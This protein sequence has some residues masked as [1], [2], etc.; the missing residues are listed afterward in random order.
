MAQ[1][2]DRLYKLLPAIYRHRD[3]EQGMP[4]RALLQVIAEQVNLVEADIAQLYENWFIETCQD[5]VVPYIGDLVGYQV[6]HEAGEPGDVTT[7][8]GR[9]HN[10]IL[11]SRRDVANTIQ[12]RRKKGTLA[13]LEQI[14]IDVAGWPARAVEFYT[15][16]GRF[17]NLSHILPQRGRYVDLRKGQALDRLNG[18]FEETA[19]TIDV[20]NSTSR[21]S[22]GRYNIPTVGLFVWRL[23]VYSVTNTRAFGAEDAGNNFF[24]FSILGNNT[25]LYT[26]PVPKAA[27]QRVSNELN[28][29]TPISRLELKE[30]LEHSVQHHQPDDYFD[31]H[32]S[33]YIWT[34]HV[35]PIEERPMIPSPQEPGH[36]HSQHH[37][38]TQHGSPVSHVVW[39][40]VAPERIIV[41]DLSDWT[42]YPHGS[43]VAVDPVLG[44]IAFSPSH[45]PDAGVRVLYHYA[46]S[47]NIGGGEYTRDLFQPQKYHL[48]RVSKTGGIRSI[49]D[50]L[51]E[52]DKWKRH[53]PHTSL[54]AVIEIMD[55]AVYT[56]NRLRTSLAEHETLQ[57]RAANGKRP[58]IRL[59]DRRPDRTD[60]LGA[61]GASN[62]TSASNSRFTLDGLLIEGRGIRISGDIAE[63][64]IRHCTL[65]P[66][67]EIDHDCVPRWRNEPSLELAETSAR[68]TIEHSILGPIHLVKDEDEGTDEDVRD[69]DDEPLHIT[70]SDSILDATDP[71]HE[72]LGTPGA[73]AANATLNILRS[74]VFGKVHVHAIELAENTIFNNDVRVV[75]SQIGCI[76]FCYLPPSSRTPRRFNC[77]PDLVQQQVDRQAADSQKLPLTDQDITEE[78]QRESD[79]VRP[80]FNSIHYGSPDY[81]QLALVCAQ[82]IQR[83]ADDESEMGVF[84]DLFQPQRAANLRARLNE[85]TPARS[86]AAIIYV[87]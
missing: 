20:R 22:A 86:T 9:L 63:V 16:L 50:A 6:A 83:G 57:I 23:K 18:P 19:H 34:G 66:G 44:R 12:D 81:C 85:Y 79:R 40:G 49:Q 77:Q 8:E 26:K 41:A 13:L 30:S 67:W 65:V 47:A 24:T 17:Q 7:S 10:K 27:S 2:I 3:V 28:Y 70:I 62:V 64:K 78:K 76:R 14:A 45:V 15:L 56:E 4:L 82:E 11:I 51:H 53:H 74:T 58:V 55:S 68:V 1:D 46:F 52:W 35:Q 71:R 61:T 29:P 60:A 38:Q 69:D 43:K 37:E 32:R 42:Y 36:A 21:L 87:N 5:W 48:F 54:N 59:L 39:E 31:P 80:V 72:A 73:I 33:L 25:Q 75:R 84:H